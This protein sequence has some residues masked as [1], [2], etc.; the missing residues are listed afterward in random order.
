MRVEQ[1]LARARED[2]DGR[3]FPVHFDG[4]QLDEALLRQRSQVARPGVA[5]RARGLQIVAR[6]R[7]GTRRPSPAFCASDSRS[8]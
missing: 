5:R 2:H 6:A 7:R 4:A 3:G 1:V 8:R